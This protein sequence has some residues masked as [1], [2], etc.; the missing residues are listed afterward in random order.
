MSIM[1]LIALRK[2]DNSIVDIFW[3]LGFCI[4]AVNSFLWAEDYDIR[5]GVTL[6]L[7][8]VWGIRLSIF[9]YNRNKVK[10]EDAR[11]EEMRKNWGENA[12]VY[13]F[14]QV[15]MLQGFFMFIISLPI[16]HIQNFSIPV[17]KI[18]DVAGIILWVI[19]FYFEAI[20]DRQKFIFAKDPANKGKFI[21]TGLWSKSRHPN[22]FGEILIWWG[23]FMLSAGCARWYISII[24]PLVVTFL[25]TKVS[26]VPM[27]EKKYDNDI[28]YQEYKKNVPAL[29]PKLL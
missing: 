21:Q 17:F 6:L 1:Y 29:F 26:G 22:Y 9:L 7:I 12:N 20:G 11:Y 8:L 18:T 16:I 10:G 23:I 24:S 13:A 28:D 5:K 14:F 3:G 15:F 27:L 19:G 4:L 25:L 2:G